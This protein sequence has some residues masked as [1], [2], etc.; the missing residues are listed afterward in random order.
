MIVS[1]KFS[2]KGQ[3]EEAPGPCIGG[4]Q[5]QVHEKTKRACRNEEKKYSF[6]G[7]KYKNLSR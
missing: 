7:R 3:C 2:K 1:G 6:L 4:N 5:D